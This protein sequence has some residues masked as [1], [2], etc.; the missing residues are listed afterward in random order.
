MF[1]KRIKPTSIRWRLLVLLLPTLAM[2][3]A[4]SLWLTHTDAL[5]SGNAAYDLVD[6]E[7]PD[8]QRACD[9]GLVMEP[10]E[11]A[12]EKPEIW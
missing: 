9:E 4:T 7:G 8:S 5:N 11:L 10:G 6:V 2:V 3:T 12:E 1:W